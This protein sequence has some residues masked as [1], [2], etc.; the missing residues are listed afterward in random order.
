MQK[1]GLRAAAPHAD[2][3]FAALSK[4]ETTPFP[5]NPIADIHDPG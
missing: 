3:I 1:W 5:V 2:P 4:K